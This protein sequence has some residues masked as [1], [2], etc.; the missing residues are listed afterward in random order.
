MLRA[1]EYCGPG[2][3]NY[4]RVIYPQGICTLKGYNG[5][6]VSHFHDKNNI[7]AGI[8]LEE[9]K[10]VWKKAKRVDMVYIKYQPNNNLPTHEDILPN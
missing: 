5:T 1:Q 4:F 9:D 6:F 7:Y 10:P 2:P 8:N 3:P